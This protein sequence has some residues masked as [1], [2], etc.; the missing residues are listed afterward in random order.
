M[1]L[2]AGLG[3]G[4][5]W[6]AFLMMPLMMLGMGLMMWFMMR[7]MMGPGGHGASHGSTDSP[8]AARGE[9]GSGSEVAVLRR[10]LAELQ[11]RLAAME[12]RPGGH[13]DDGKPPIAA[14]NEGEPPASGKGERV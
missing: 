3:D 4:F 13:D 1:F 2:D 8:A 12:S 14:S 7:M 6:W 11:Q 10:Q 9:E 5:P